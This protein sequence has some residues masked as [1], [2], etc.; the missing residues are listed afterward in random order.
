MT[1]KFSQVA[2]LYLGCEVETQDGILKFD[3]IDRRHDT[4]ICSETM[5]VYLLSEC[6]PRLYSLSDITEKHAKELVKLKHQCLDVEDIAIVKHDTI[7]TGFA[8]KYPKNGPIVPT[9][10]NIFFDKLTAAQ[11]LYLLEQKVWLFGD[12]AFE[13]REIVKLTQTT[14]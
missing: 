2:H 8:Y 3:N 1:K 7:N 11:F 9:C 13:K 5:K 10:G 6:K 12:E 14:P 4:F